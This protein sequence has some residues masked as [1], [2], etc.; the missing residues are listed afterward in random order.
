MILFR[1][2]DT[3]TDTDTA[4]LSGNGKL[5]CTACN[6]LPLLYHN[7]EQII[8]SYLRN[9]A[10]RDCRRGTPND[11]K[12]PGQWSQNFRNKSSFQKSKR[13]PPPSVCL[14]ACMHVAYSH[15]TRFQAVLLPQALLITHPRH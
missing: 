10:E 2:S 5:L 13:F 15:V 7:G 6:T 1:F 12:E 4:R 9:P 14:A 8:G 3:D 11:Y